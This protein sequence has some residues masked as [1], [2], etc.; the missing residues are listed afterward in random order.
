M[1][2]YIHLWTNLEYFKLLNSWF[3]LSLSKSDEKE[4]IEFFS[5]NY[6]WELE[7]K[8]SAQYKVNFESLKQ[9]KKKFWVNV[10][11]KINWIYYW[12]DNCEYLIPTLQETKEALQLFHEFNKKYP[13]HIKRTFSFVTPYTWNKMMTRLRESLQYLNEQSKLSWNS[14]EIVVNDFWVLRLLKKE[15]TNLIPIFWRLLHKLLKTPLIDS[16]GYTVHPSWESIK[17]KNSEEIT[18]LKE[19]IIQWQLKFYS[20]SECSLEVYQ[21]FLKSYGVS[22]ITIDYMSQ[23]KELYNNANYSNIWI[24]LYYPWALVFTWRLCDTSAIENPSRWYYATDDICPRTCNRYDIN[25]K[26]KTNDYNLIQRWN[27]GYRSEVNL[28]NL[29]SE[30]SSNLNNRLIYSPFITV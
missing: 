1:N 9:L 17:N 21:N 10:F 18:I 8:L 29:N 28:D 26:I 24:D 15:F 25:Y 19:Q 23:R 5:K 14:F 30:F 16:F 12:S 4:I 2:L 27:A 6:P 11:D 7:E 20:S 22:R 13:P 3:L